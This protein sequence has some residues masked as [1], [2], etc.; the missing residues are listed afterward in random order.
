M[1]TIF[2]KKRKLGLLDREDL[3]VGAIFFWKD[4]CSMWAFIFGQ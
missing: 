3:E 2:G 1:R 4:I